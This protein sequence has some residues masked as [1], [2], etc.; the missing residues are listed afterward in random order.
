MT[1][2]QIESARKAE[3]VDIPAPTPED[4]E[5]LIEV[6]ACGICGTDLHI[7]S[8]EYGNL[9]I[10][11]G[12]ECAGVVVDVGAGVRSLQ[13]GDRVAVEPNISCGRCEMC[14]IGRSNFCEHWEAVGVTRP[15]AM[16][17]YVSVPEA[18]AF[19]IGPLSF[20]QAL[21]MEPLSCVIHGVE[22]AHVALAERI[23]V[24][25]AGPIGILLLQACKSAGASRVDVIDRQEARLTHAE[26]NG[27][28]EISTELV[29]RQ[30]E[31]YDVVID[32]TGVPGV[33]EQS[34][35]Y[36]K[37]GGRLL[38]FGV[39]PEDAQVSIEPFRL[40]RREL[41]LLSSFTSVRNSLQALRMLRCNALRV[42]ELISHR[43]SLH[44]LCDAFQW[45]EAGTKE[46]MK[47]IVSPQIELEKEG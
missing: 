7:Y 3:L 21:F 5:V 47:V 34:I 42:E 15:G 2:F 24:I 22:R 9:P 45:L 8:G 41:T 43:V 39:P 35:Y 1:A 16:A 4:G 38:W 46:S 14:R 32:A 11:P 27:A 17:E 37:P 18:A 13:P 33:L 30:E 10:V 20:E 36:A 6:R 28:C 23:L 40:F 25:G 26:Q 44:D 29:T 31:S 19:D 12:H